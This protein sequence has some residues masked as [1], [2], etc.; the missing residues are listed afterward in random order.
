MRLRL[1]SVVLLASCGFSASRAEEPRDVVARAVKAMGGEELLAMKLATAVKVRGKILQPG[2]GDRT[3]FTGHLLTQ[4]ARARRYDLSIEQDGNKFDYS[5]IIVEGK[6]WRIIPGGAVMDVAE[7]ELRQMSY[8]LDQ[9]R[10]AA[11]LPLLQDKGYTLTSLE[12]TEVEG[13]PAVGIKAAFKDRQDSLLWFD[14]KTG[15][16]VKT[17]YKDKKE[18]LLETVLADYREAGRED[19]ERLL[20]GAELET[21]ARTL[22]AYLRRQTPDAAKIAQVR[23][24]IRKL[25]DETFEVREQAVK[26]LVLLEKVAIPFLQQARKDGDAEVVRRAG[27]CLEQIEKRTNNATIQAAIRFVGWTRPEGGAAALLALLPGVEEVVANEVRAV[28]VV[29]A[30]RDGKPD[31]ALV[32]ALDDKEPIIR[33]VAVAVLGRDGGEYLKQPGRQLFVRGLKQ[34]MRSKY[35]EGGKASFE[36]QVIEFRVVNR[37][38]PKLFEKPAT[39]N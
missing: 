8:Q 17:A 34:A 12:E 16:L 29:Y 39:G 37:L 28:L 9:D 15:F 6:G 22:L 7:E 10:A 18:K 26:D 13:R 20:H 36:L 11:L 14:K 21:D 32:L 19:D 38:D 30:E 31:P 3:F 5:Q 24:L 25:G 33:A 2:L 35:F 23:T 1:L 27:E 4:S